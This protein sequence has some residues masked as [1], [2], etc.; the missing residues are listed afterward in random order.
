MK[1][2]IAVLGQGPAGC[3]AAYRL[4]RLAGAEVDIHLLGQDLAGRS[5][6]IKVD[7]AY[8]DLG[9][10]LITDTYQLVPSY[11]RDLGLSASLVPL[12]P[13]VTVRRVDDGALGKLILNDPLS[14]LTYPLLSLA[15][16]ARLVG[17]LLELTLT[18]ALP[19]FDPMSLD[20]VARLDT[21]Q[22]LAQY[23]TARVGKAGL[24]NLGVLFTNLLRTTPDRV[25]A[26]AFKAWYTRPAVQYHVM[27]NG[28][29]AIWSGLVGRL[30][31]HTVKSGVT[32]TKVTR[33]AAPATGYTVTL[34]D[35]MGPRTEDYDAVI[36][37]LPAPQ[38]DAVA[39]P[40][41]S[42]AVRGVLTERTYAESVVGIYRV[43]VPRATPYAQGLLFT[44]GAGR[45]DVAAVHLHRRH[46]L[47]QSDAVEDFAYVYPQDDFAASLKGSTDAA[48][49]D[50]LYAHAQADLLGSASWLTRAPLEKIHLGRYRYGTVS[51]PVTGVV[52]RGSRDLAAAQVGSP[53]QIAGSFTE[54]PVA[55]CMETAA[56][57]GEKAAKRLLSAL[58]GRTY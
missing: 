40:L 47:N 1:K 27:V 53:L 34:D 2:K 26:A 39:G 52:S 36:L 56:R 33:A 38:V 43:S 15:D 30:G 8:L 44:C 50:A 17:P 28:V 14:L 31:G 54:Q 22:S 19:S 37:A 49:L 20:A 42:G 35:G 25:P 16:K 57:S 10:S 18:G 21:A 29:G 7:D 3:A 45:R 11:I 13:E 4:D 46:K 51:Y 58:F 5:S 6:T 41:F 32:V 55:D 48:A 12:K 24:D 23:L 9:A